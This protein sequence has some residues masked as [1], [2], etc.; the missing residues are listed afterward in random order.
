[1]SPYIPGHSLRNT[2][3]PLPEDRDRLR[4]GLVGHGLGRYAAVIMLC[5]R[6]EA[7]GRLGAVYDDLA[8]RSPERTSPPWVRMYSRPLHTPPS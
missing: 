7:S 3:S 6:L 4:L 2:D 8:A 5:I 1:M